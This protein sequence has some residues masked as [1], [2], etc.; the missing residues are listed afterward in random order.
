MCIRDSVYSF[1]HQVVYQY[2]DICFVASQ[3]E[4]F[5]TVTV[6]Y[7]HLDVYKRQD[8]DNNV[9]FVRTVGDSQ[10]RFR[11]FHFD[12]SLRR[13]ESARGT[14]YESFGG[15]KVYHTTILP[16]TR[17]VGGPMD[18]TPGIFETHCRCV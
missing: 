16:F 12:E 1:G 9:Y 2:T 13:R 8:R 17:L 10:C 11:Y 14:E 6:S 15:N 3:C 4:G 5:T 7:T 18:Y